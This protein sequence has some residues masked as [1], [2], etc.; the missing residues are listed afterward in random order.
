M[1]FYAVFHG[2]SP[3]IDQFSQKNTVFAFFVN[4]GGACGRAA[5]APIRL[6]SRGVSKKT[7]TTFGVKV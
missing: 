3:I 6:K 7:R 2:F 5:S 1:R 4:E